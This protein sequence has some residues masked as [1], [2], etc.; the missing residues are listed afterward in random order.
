MLGGTRAV[1]L[2]LGMQNFLVF[3]I[4]DLWVTWPGFGAKTVIPR[5]RPTG[6]S[7]GI[8]LHA[9]TVLNPSKYRKV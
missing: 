6:S 9:K 3:G 4:P 2:E 5:G 1:S 7:E 8:E